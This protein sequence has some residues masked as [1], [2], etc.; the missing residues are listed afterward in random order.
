M[1]RILL[2][3]STIWVALV[4]SAVA[5]LSLDRVAWLVWF[6]AWV[7]S[8]FLVRSL[9]GTWFSISTVYLT[10]FGAY[11]LSGPFEVLF[12]SGT[13]HSFNPPYQSSLWLSL[14][15]AALASLALGMFCVRLVVPPPTLFR[16][17]RS[18][19]ER[20]LFAVAV[21]LVVVA[22]LGELTNFHR[23]GGLPT[24]LSGKAV[25]QAQVSALTLTFPSNQVGVVAFALLGVHLSRWCA[26]LNQKLGHLAWFALCSLPLVGIHVFLGRR[27]EVAA[28]LLALLL[29]YFAR[30]QV[31]RFPLKLAAVLLC[32]YVLAAPLYAFRWA[33]PML[34]LRQPIHMD[35]H[36]ALRYALAALNPARNEFG[37]PFGNFSTYANSGRRELLLGA[38]YLEDIA[39]AIPA[40]LY[41]GRRPTS[42]VYT[43]RDEFFPEKR[44]RS[45]IAGTAFSSILE[46][47][48]N[49][50]ALGPL[51]FTGFGALLSAL[52]ALRFYSRSPYMLTFYATFSTYA[53]AAHRSSTGG[54]F[55]HYLWMAFWVFCAYLLSRLIGGRFT[56][57]SSQ[58]PN[59]E[60][61][62]WG[63]LGQP[64]RG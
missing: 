57:R 52:E 58:V 2:L 19:E 29:G 15:G 33:F 28:W 55:G 50:G 10:F 27:L 26:R 6:L 51:V 60:A 53:L 41:P 7:L 14:A 4:S 31:A 49:F 59:E 13:L 18:A 20:T 3:L 38:S 42:V 63:Y 35:T 16:P 39:T 47:Y 8:L 21:T 64:G 36:E 45:D 17:L 56:L 43:F 48:M 25:Y 11:T 24:L 40:F 1:T 44:E 54:M 46:A 30:T 9:W 62:S 22:S 5:L 32:L 23:V 37:A 61:N 34:V 12:G